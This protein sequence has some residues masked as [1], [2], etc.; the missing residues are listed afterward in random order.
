ME[1]RNVI[2]SSAKSNSSVRLAA[3][4]ARGGEEEE[5]EAKPVAMS[6]GEPDKQAGTLN[7]IPV[8]DFVFASMTLRFRGY[9]MSLKKGLVKQLRSGNFLR[10][11]VNI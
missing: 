4:A 5:E 6:G 11:Q 10:L 9:Q 3:P 2:K 8:S 7:T 1:P